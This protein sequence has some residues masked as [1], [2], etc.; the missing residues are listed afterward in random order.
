MMNNPSF[1]DDLPGII[2]AD[3]CLVARKLFYEPVGKALWEHPDY[4][5]VADQR[6]IIEAPFRNPYTAFGTGH[7]VA[8]TESASLIAVL[9]MMSHPPCYVIMS[10]ASW[11]NL[12]ERLMPA[13]RSKVEIFNRLWAPTLGEEKLL[14]TPLAT[15]W[16]LGDEWAV[17]CMSPDKSE[18]AQGWHSPG[19]TL[20]MVDEASHENLNAE[21]FESLMSFA[22]AI[23]LFGN[24]N[25]AEGMFADILRRSKG[26]E[27]W[28]T[29]T[30]DTRN[31]PNCRLTQEAIDRG[32]MTDRQ[33]RGL[34]G[35]AREIIA[36]QGLRTYAYCRRIEEKYGEESPV[37]AGRVRGVPPDQSEDTL[38]SFRTFNRACMAGATV[39]DPDH[40]TEIM[41]DV[42]WSEVGDESVVG[43]SNRHGLIGEEAGRGWS[44][45]ELR[46]R[47]IRKL[48]SYPSIERLYIDR[49]GVGGMLYANVLG[50]QRGDVEGGPGQR[51]L[52]L[53]VDIIGVA[54]N[55]PAADPAE[56]SNTRAECWVGMR[57]GLKA[58]FKI[59]YK[60]RDNFI[61]MTAMKY[62]PDNDGRIK[63]QKKADYKEEQG[64]SPDHEDMLALRWARGP[65]GDRM[66][67][68]QV[69]CCR[70]SQPPE[71]RGNV[72]AVGGMWRYGREGVLG[73]ALVYSRHG[74]SGAVW[75]HV[76]SEGCWTVYRCCTWAE[77]TSLEA[78]AGDYLKQYMAWSNPLKHEPGLVAVDLFTSM[79]DTNKGGE[80]S[81][82]DSLVE[83]AMVAD[84]EIPGWVDPT[85]LAKG[86]GLDTLTGMIKTSQQV[87]KG[88]M[89]ERVGYALASDIHKIYY[90]PM[91]AVWPR[92]VLADLRKVKLRPVTKQQAWEKDED[93][94]R[95]LVGMGGPLV[96]ALRLLICNGLGYITP[97][98]E[99]GNDAQVR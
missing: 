21:M 90:P 25:R 86:G 33:A 77:G 6:S 63:I 75:V 28:V 72:L 65:V 59:P 61:G 98:I 53:G 2:L 97:R 16:V 81:P 93:R 26:T 34:D 27:E 56:Y 40:P 87:A 42:A 45:I 29:H 50:I 10:S 76:D 74:R 99:D 46:G 78:I 20:V 95:D 23:V 89:Q 48:E 92:E 68:D 3:P 52:L 83:L 85:L 51:D 41:V 39:V 96:G 12:E 54:G 31:N 15:K 84:V 17:L 67:G 82:Y 4:P 43:W 60:Y 19:G 57:D 37:F 73:K 24:P 94:G 13:L 88:D 80:I 62:E 30:I 55:L 14:P 44:E 79:D 49:D 71:L 64:R 7:G 47:V 8:K 18:V 58:G 70:M 91:L 5:L 22:K 66:W 38:I 1:M 36:I 69:A 9:W 11:V 35:P 32:E